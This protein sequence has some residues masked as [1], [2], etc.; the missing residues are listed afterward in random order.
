MILLILS[1]MFNI[2]EDWKT[3][4]ISNICRL[5]K[6]KIF[7]FF[8]NPVSYLFN[9]YHISNLEMQKKR[10]TMKSLSCIVYTWSS[11]KAPSTLQMWDCRPPLDVIIFKDYKMSSHFIPPFISLFVFNCWSM[12]QRE[13]II[14][15]DGEKVTFPDIF[16]LW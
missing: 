4:I 11:L 14:H 15:D 1:L 9:M 12:T 3:S 6:V 5:H 13:D 2:W 8:I 16:V 7:T 10:C